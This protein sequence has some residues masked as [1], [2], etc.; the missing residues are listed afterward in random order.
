LYFPT[1]SLKNF[2][3][4]PYEVINFA[5]SCEYERDELDRWAGV[6]SQCLSSVNINLFHYSCGKVLKMIFG[7][8]AD[9]IDY[10]AINH[11]QKITNDDINFSNVGWVH[12]DPDMLTAIIYLSENQGSGT[13]ILN[14]PHEGFIDYSKQTNVPTNKYGKE[15]FEDRKEKN[16]S[17]YTDSVHHDSTFNSLLAF[18]GAHPH[19][20]IFNMKENSTRLTQ[21]IFFKEIKAPWYPIPEMNLLG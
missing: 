21:I 17:F 18:Q 14:K 1:Y 5:N 2:Y 20:A 3:Q 15:N 16:N 4:N 6:R 10:Q 9:A 19:K 12:Q 11:F 7:K 13:K 8:S